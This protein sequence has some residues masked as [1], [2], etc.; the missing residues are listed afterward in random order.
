LEEE[1]DS[2]ANS[3]HMAAGDPARLPRRL[4][5]IQGIIHNRLE[6]RRNYY[7][8]RGALPLLADAW[9]A[10]VS[11]ETLESLA[12]SVDFRTWGQYREAVA[13]A[14]S[15][16]GGPGGEFSLM[17]SWCVASEA[18]EEEFFAQTTVDRVEF[19]FEMRSICQELRVPDADIRAEVSGRRVGFQSFVR[20]GDGVVEVGFVELVVALGW[21]AV[22]AE[23]LPEGPLV[24]LFR[25]D[26]TAAA[27]QDP[28]GEFDGV[29]ECSSVDHGDVF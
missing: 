12:R 4:F 29:T 26:A 18:G 24:G 10:G 11:V 2:M 21:R 9:R 7:P 22:G 25:T 20:S 1:A 14:V 3:E 27:P 23:I 6:E 16:V 28:F 5:Y 13:D 8:A 17:M 19:T 15:R